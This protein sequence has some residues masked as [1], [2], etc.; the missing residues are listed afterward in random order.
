MEVLTLASSTFYKHLKDDQEGVS[1]GIENKYVDILWGKIIQFMHCPSFGLLPCSW[2]WDEMFFCTGGKEALSLVIHVWTS[3]ALF[4]HF[5]L[6]LQRW[7]EI[8]LGFV[9]L[10]FP[11][12]CLR[13]TLA[14][15]LSHVY[16]VGTLTLLRK[17]WEMNHVLLGCLAA[18]FYLLELS[19]VDLLS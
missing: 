13:R 17:A 4:K 8:G 18:A 5:C 19:T 16:Y 14:L 10:G 6:S 1:K 11:K 12:F 9:F 3:W 7:L 2:G 15:W